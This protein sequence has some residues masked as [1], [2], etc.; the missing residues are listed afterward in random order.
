M[1]RLLAAL[2]LAAFLGA[3]APLSA[4]EVPHLEFVRELRARYPDLAL[5]YLE[6]LRKS[7]PPPQLAAAI[8]LELAKVH[9]DLATGEADPHRRLDLYNKARAEFQQ[10]IDKNPANVLVADAKVDLARV[11]ALQAKAQLSRALTEEDAAAR[12]RGALEARQTFLLAN[13]QLQAAA[14]Q[15]ARD[16][17]KYPDPKTPQETA[18]KRALLQAHLQARLDLGV[19]LIDQAETY[20]NEG[21]AEVALARSK[22][23]NQAQTAL[24]AVVK[25]A[26][27]NNPIGWQA[28]AWVA[29]CAVQNGD[30]GKALRD[31]DGI[32]SRTEPGSAAGKR[33]AYFFKLRIILDP[34]ANPKEADVASAR[35]E[36]ETWLADFRTYQGTP[37]GCGVR[38]YLA[39]VLFRQAAEAKEK[40]ART[41]LLNRARDL[42]LDLTK[43]DNEY[44]LRARKLGIQ[45]MGAEG[46]FNK[47]IAK[48][49]SFEECLIR[50]EYE[51]SMAEDLSR[52][53]KEMKPEAFDKEWNARIGNA[54]EALKM[55]LDFSARPGAKISP[56]EAGKARY[57]LCGYYLFT[58]KFKESIAVGEDAARA[59]PPTA[60][61][62][63]TAEY[64]I[65]AYNELIG[66]SLHK[67]TTLADLSE[68]GGPV[69]RMDELAQ[70]MIKQWPDD[71]PGDVARHMRGLLLIKQK[72]LPEAVELLAKV[73][74]RYPSL[75]YVKSSLSMAAGQ[76]AQDREALAKAEPDKAKKEQLTKEQ[77][78][79][80]QQAMDAVKSMPPLPAGAD[81]LTA[82]LYIK[83]KIDLASA[84][85][86]R[87]E[88]AEIDKVVDPLLADL[89]GGKIRLDPPGVEPKPGELTPTEEA[90]NSLQLVKLY[91]L[92]GLADGELAAGHA[93]KVKAIT[94]PIVDEIRKGGHPALNENPTL[95]WGLMGLA[96]RVSI[97]EGNTGRA[98][99]I[100]EAAKKFAGAK[101]GDK[102]GNSK[103]ILLQIAGM[104]KDQAREA[105][106]KKDEDA[107]K[108]YT[109]FLDKLRDGEKE[110]T[111]EFRRVMAE[112]YGA[113]G[114]HDAAVE[115]ARL[116]PAPTGDDAKDDRKVSNYHFCRI[117][118]VRE[119]RVAGKKDES[120][121]ELDMV[122]K[123]AWAKDHPE[124]TKEGIHLLTPGKAY[125]KWSQLVTQLGQKIQQ[126]GMKEQYFE[127]YY[128][129]VQSMVDYA[130]E[131]ANKAKKTDYMKR[132]AGLITKLEGPWPDLGG[133]ESKARFTDLL[134]REPALKEQY[135]KAKGAK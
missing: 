85:Y 126:P 114:Q 109:Q 40:S 13:T 37:E 43:V 79:Y 17:Q 22:V 100:Y 64:V 112:A 11:T 52:K 21:N 110:P 44:N 116:V 20:V 1:K 49:T 63:K 48:L 55:A 3:A 25:D 128:Y 57:M 96:L 130:N 34:P 123:E 29:Y 12:E 103:V 120:K 50:A 131:D 62:G 67:G 106:K 54:V 89:A 125:G 53:Q 134:E 72:K 56:A 5:E 24:N 129:M 83:S 41:P 111:P 115:Q 81:A 70:F 117:L 45:V 84:Y 19:N 35:K 30:P 51:G 38:Y 76:V 73:S 133:D 14:D 87:K 23:I 102:G 46:D 18:A 59:V 75:I 42:C 33:L 124:V 8:P 122:Q 36:A 7:N 90:R 27:L 66:D 94:D 99:E 61:S 113:L 80:E 10:F 9:L 58:K 31:L 91:G 28:R 69:T 26:E 88:Y 32:I 65:E 47:D 93:A 16:V 86:R 15:L 92:Y 132:A 95:R 77:V 97:Q 135:D 71:A 118:V 105:R 39:D 121:A 101:E 2:A 107:L 68:P 78:Q 104:V 119:L 60:Q 108:K 74:P 6:N 82:R 98:L 4:E 127:C